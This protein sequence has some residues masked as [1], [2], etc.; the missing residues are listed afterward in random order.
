MFLTGSAE[1][2]KGFSHCF[3]LVFF[4]LVIVKN[5]I[6]LECAGCQSRLSLLEESAGQCL[7]SFC[8]FFLQSFLEVCCHQLFS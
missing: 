4:F 3:G 6:V 2:V 8:S 1:K 7:E 5:K